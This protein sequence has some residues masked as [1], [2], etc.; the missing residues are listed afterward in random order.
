MNLNSKIIFE[1]FLS[2]CISHKRIYFTLHNFLP[3][4]SLLVDGNLGV[5]VIVEVP[6]RDAPDPRVEAGV[7]HVKEQ[8]F[9]PDLR[10]VP[11]L[12]HLSFHLLFHSLLDPLDLSLGYQARMHDAVPEVGDR[13]LVLPHL[14][15]LLAGPEDTK[16]IRYISV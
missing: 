3:S 10:V 4:S 2:L 12:L 16:D 5:L 9:H 11:S 13:V 8:L 7:V 1:L 14:L 6:G 15:Y